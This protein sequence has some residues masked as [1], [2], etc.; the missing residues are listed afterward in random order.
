MGI[1]RSNSGRVN[2]RRK[3]GGAGGIVCLSATSLDGHA[4]EHFLRFTLP[5]YSR[6]GGLAAM[7]EAQGAGLAERLETR[8]SAQ[9]CADDL[10]NTLD[11]LSSF[12]SAST[13]SIPPSVVY[14]VH[15][16]AGQIRESQL[17]H[18]S[19]ARSY[20]KAIWIASSTDALR[21]DELAL[22]QHRL[23]KVYGRQGSYLRAK[24]LLNNAI[25]TYARAN[26]NPT[27]P[28]VVDARQACQENECHYWA[29]DSSWSSLRSDH[30][31]E[32]IA[33]EEPTNR[34]F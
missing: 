4:L 16:L 34:S 18:E 10:T 11:V 12:L 27:H 6:D 17:N 3:S 5:R 15:F 31:L 33:E 23:G 22:A 13:S 20:L 25:A 7:A 2:S 8:S 24:E 32:L 9:G 30:R 29:S 14:E 26:Y 19:A 21:R 1:R 28:F